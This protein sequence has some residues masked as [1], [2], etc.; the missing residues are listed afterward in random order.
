MARLRHSCGPSS[1]GDVG[2]DI[3]TLSAAA[4]SSRHSLAVKMLETDAQS[5]DHALASV[6]GPE[7]LSRAQQSF[8]ISQFWQQHHINHPVLDEDSF[9]KHFESLWASRAASCLTREQSPLVDIMLAISIQFNSHKLSH[10]H[11]FHYFENDPGR[12][13]PSACALANFHYHR[14]QRALKSD[15]QQPSLFT[16]QSQ[17]FAVIYLYRS[18]LTSMAYNHLGM[19][20]RIAYTLGL[21]QDPHESLPQV[22]RELHRRIWWCL[23]ILDTDI[24]LE[25]GRPEG[26]QLSCS[27]C[28]LPT[29]D[30][31][32]ATPSSRSSHTSQLEMTYL[33]FHLQ[34]IQLFIV[35]RSIYVEIYGNSKAIDDEMSQASS[36]EDTTK[37]KT[38][39]TAADLLQQRSKDM[40]S[41]AD[42]LPT[43]LKVGRRDGGAPLSC[44][45]KRIVLDN[46][47]SPWLQRQRLLLE[48]HYHNLTMLLHRPLMVSEASEK[49]SSNKAEPFELT[50]LNHATAITTI[51]HQIC[52]ESDLLNGTFKAQS[53]LWNA[54]ITTIGFW[55]AHKES[56]Q[57]ESTSKYV[58]MAMEVFRMFGS[59]NSMASTGAA[60][61]SSFL[62]SLGVAK[63]GGRVNGV[64]QDVAMEDTGSSGL[65]KMILPGGAGRDRGRGFAEPKE[66]LEAGVFAPLG[67]GGIVTSAEAQDGI[68]ATWDDS[69]LLD[70]NVD[71]GNFW[72][73]LEDG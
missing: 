51:V 64:G 18:S 38:A 69:L 59:Q 58:G 23:Y 13:S 19:V 40:Q 63:N 72:P 50:C 52:T 37:A 56:A 11:G 46:Y 55:L 39:R 53:T 8:Y 47:A 10:D 68:S 2:N 27:D 57:A 54:M 1:C 70:L 33:A 65:G 49:S 29:D 7:L 44:S 26:V 22:A 4:M 12:Q 6:A 67:P 71:A 21:H 35:A 34:C 16:F 15:L 45:N 41:W 32:T 5:F 73:T 60:I 31:E 28:G 3:C 20:I 66:L 48:L 25:L 36:S 14:S 42:D 24:S 43:A 62:A 30:Q 61:A 17:F 9:E